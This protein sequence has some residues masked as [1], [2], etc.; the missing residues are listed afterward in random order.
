LPQLKQLAQARATLSFTT[1]DPKRLA[2]RLREAVAASGAHE[3][4]A[5]LYEVNRHYKFKE[6]A[7]AVIAIFFDS[8]VMGE[9]I[10]PAI[11][12]AIPEK[13]TMPGVFS[14]VDVLASCVKFGNEQELYFPDALVHP[15][16][17]KKLYEW[18]QTIGEWQ[19]IDHTLGGGTGLTLTK[20]ELPE[21]IAWQPEEES[22][23]ALS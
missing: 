9:P 11:P 23:E 3:E 22:G 15:D 14:F 6:E 18:C 20:K 4:Y 5:D 10:G 17:Q 2:Y 8:G 12:R 16:E 13:K 7:H 1:D 19:Y 21:G